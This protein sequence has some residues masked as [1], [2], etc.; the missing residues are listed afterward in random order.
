MHITAADGSG[1]S[2]LVTE[3]GRAPQ[4][5]ADNDH[6]YVTRSAV[7]NEVDLV[8]NLVRVKRDKSDEQIVA[9]SEFANEFS[10]SPDG[11]W[12]AYR[13]RFQT[14]VTPMPLA[15]RPITV[16]K[17]A[18]PLP[19]KQ[20]SI[21][22]GDYL[23]WSGDSKI[24]Y[25]SLGDELFTRPLADAFAFMDGGSTSTT[26]PLPA[27]G[28]N[29]VKI[30]FIVAADKPATTTVINGARIITMK[31]DEVINDGRIVVKG[32]RIAAI[33]KAADIAIP[34]GATQIDAKG[35]SIM[36]GMV[37]A[38]WHGGMGAQGIVPQ[39]SWVNYAS[40]AFGVTTLHDPSNDT[41]TIFTVAEMQKSGKVV[42]P[43]IFSTGTILYGAKASITAEVNGLDDAFTH[44]KRMK[45]AGAYTV[46]SY[47]Q[48]RR[49]QRQQVLEAA[50]QT[51]MMVVPEGGS[52]FQHNMNMIIDGHT[53]IEHAIPVANAY[54]D[55]K[56]LWSQ[57]K[58]GYTPTF[59]VGYGGLDGEHYW[60]AKSDVW[61]H[62]LLTKYVPR[63]LLQSRA[64]RR[65]TAPEEDYN[66]LKIAKTA[67]ALQR[68]GVSVNIGAHGQ[69]EGLGS[70][71]EMW[72]AAKGGMTSLE[73]IRVATLNGAKYLGMDRDVGSLEVGKLADLIIIDADILADVYQ[74]DRITHVMQNGRVFDV[75]TMNEVGATP[76]A[77]KAF[78]FESTPGLSVGFVAITSLGELYGHDDGVCHH[79]H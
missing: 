42:G 38:H 48:P 15:G 46:K 74:S 65:T 28:E 41:A 3:E 18:T 29:G 22:A 7:T 70:H 45:A 19:T 60:Y 49:D 51:G 27:M 71:W 10:L 55:V 66:I 14:Y 54:D 32:N 30:G 76:K 67:T 62:P 39:Q 37:D 6:L 79:A 36:P 16:G 12:L 68:A 25:F 50:R 5:G 59:N 64:V 72:M 13:E 47:N 35:K 11:Q 8:T 4:Y 40:L 1:A 2:S 56:Q 21:N 77:R 17:K 69:R 43:R 63:A 26:T 23:H 20:L 53:G 9:K 61:L 33:G 52:L 34:A 57:T 73:A 58:V 24:V 44:L 75:A 78:F 31:G